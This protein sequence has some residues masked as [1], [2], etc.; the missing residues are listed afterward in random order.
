MPSRSFHRSGGAK[1]TLIVVGGVVV[2]VAVGLIVLFASRPGQDDSGQTILLH[3]VERKD[4]EAFITEP[5]DVESSSNVEVR[6]L[7]KSRGGAGIPIL[8]IEAEGKFVVTG[9]FLIQF[10]DSVL[11]N[12]LLAQMIVAA[13][14]RALLIQAQSDAKTAAHTLREYTKGLFAQ[15]RDVIESE[16]FVAK[17]TLQRAITYL[18]YSRRLAARGYI[19][20]TQ[21]SADEFAVDKARKDVASTTR[22]LDVYVNFTRDKMVGEYEAGVEKQKANVKAATLTLE[23]SQKKLALIKEQIAH[24]LVKAPADGQVVHAKERKGRGDAPA[25]IEEGTVIRD[26]QVVIRLPDIR[27]MQVDVKINESHV[28]RIEPGD[29]ARIELDADPDNILIG[30]VKEVAAYPFPLR[31]HGAPLE[32]GAVVTIINPPKTIRPGL[33]AKVMI[34]FES[35]PNAL[36]VPLAAIIEHGGRHYCLVREDRSWRP[37]LVR[38]GPNNNNHIIVEDGIDEGDQVAITPFRYIDRSDLPD[39]KLPAD[40]ADER[41]QRNAAEKPEKDSRQATNSR[42][43]PVTSV[44]GS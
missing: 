5:G 22:K 3:T 32:Y 1:L 9:D 43:A 30:V 33:R 36:Q 24:C 40:T 21:L 14:D 31:W 23:L 19:N 35:R 34:S 18:D 7:V 16:L 37:K 38:I 15:E 4:F 42:I 8:K 29:P 41:S 20:A 11:Q 10:D 28:N 13:N 12:E 6:C 39:L 27:K 2:A 44:P 17:E 26:N 25:V